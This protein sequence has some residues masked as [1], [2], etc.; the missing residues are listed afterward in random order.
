MKALLCLLCILIPTVGF[1]QS[2]LETLREVR[3]AYPAAGP[4]TPV[5]IGEMLNFVAWT[6]RAEGWRLLG[7][8]DGN[9]CPMPDGTPISCDYLVH[10]ATLEGFDVFV[11]AGGATTVHWSGPE[12][13]SQMIASGR[14]TV[15]MPVVPTSGTPVPNPGNVHDPGD[16]HDVVNFDP[17]P[18]LNAIAALQAKLTLLERQLAVLDSR[19]ANGELFADRLGQSFLQHKMQDSHPTGC[20]AGLN[21]GAFRIPVSCQVK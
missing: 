3:K 10:S 19:I 20:E 9:T 4:V 16:V 14:R 1:A 18:L 8:K 2:P 11:D 6:H 5:Q 15:V 21:F 7:K 17:Q 12:P 13:L